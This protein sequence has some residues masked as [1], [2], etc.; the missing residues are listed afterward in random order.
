ML[1]GGDL[2]INIFRPT[3]HLIDGWIYKGQKQ[4]AFVTSVSLPF[5]VP[6]WLL[7]HTLIVA[8]IYTYECVVECPLL[9]RREWQ[10]VS[11]RACMMDWDCRRLGCFC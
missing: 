5:F 1:A 8:I 4:V 3:G 10:A 6:L 11:A 7:L 9:L 2:I